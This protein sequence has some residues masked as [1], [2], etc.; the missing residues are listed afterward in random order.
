MA[1]SGDR[2]SLSFVGDESYALVNKRANMGIFSRGALAI[3]TAAMLIISTAPVMAAV[4]IEQGKTVLTASG[5]N[6]G[7][8]RRRYRHRDRVDGGD[9]LAGMAILAGIAIVAEAASK[10]SQRGRD[11][12]PGDNYPQDSRRDSNVSRGNDVGTAVETCSVAA[13]RDNSR[14]DEIRSVTRDGNGWRVEGGLTGGEVRN[15]TCG[16]TYGK[17]DFI[18]FGERSI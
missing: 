17:V 1:Q 4:S 10:D 9:I 2:L 13:E 18:Q 7:W 15:F 14:V 5:G 3:G 8:N 11:R 16:T 6:N 12:Y